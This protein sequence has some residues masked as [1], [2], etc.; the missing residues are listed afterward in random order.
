M[1]REIVEKRGWIGDKEFSHALGFCM[2]LPG[3]EAQQ[4][5]TYIGWRLHGIRGAL[6][7]GSL[8]VLPAA[9]LL[10]V[11]SV[12]AL[13][14]GNSPGVTAFLAGLQPV[15][16]ATILSA[17]LRLGRRSLRGPFAAGIAA[18]AFLAVVAAHASFPIVLLGAL[19]VGFVWPGRFESP[20]DDSAE[21]YIP[22]R[23]TAAAAWIA[24]AAWLLPVAAL[25]IWERGVLSDI[26]S[27][28]SLT[29]VMTFGGAYAVLPYVA[30]HATAAGWATAE[31]VV[32]G[33]GLAEATPG[34][35][36]L[37]NQFIGFFAA[38]GGNPNALLSATLG[39]AI[40]AWTT[41][42]PS[43]VWIFS[44]APHLERIRRSRRLAGAMACV[45]AAVVGVVASLGFWLARHV[46]L[47]GNGVLDLWACAVFAAA[48]PL[49]SRLGVLPVLLLGG[50]AGLAR[51][52][53]GV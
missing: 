45:G 15:V 17:C 40:A 49:L 48:L 22:R 35:L 25:A 12:V 38:A 33:I 18:G 37:V 16:V 11:L 26:A 13:R 6:V 28:F 50:G 4:L 43:F 36:V 20:E 7:A 30:K 3:P 19:A 21:T 14:G 51:W 39:G 52:L 42:A 44:G 32:Q 53:L 29:S 31:Q 9:L 5:A 2:L 46:F 8:F 27:F 1:H 41:F 47:P 34:P 24:L 10:W 23:S